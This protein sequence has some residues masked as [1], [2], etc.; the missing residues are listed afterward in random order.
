MSHFNANIMKNILVTIDFSENEKLLI[1]K[2]LEMAKA[3]NAKIWLLH[4]V[5]PEPE[6]VGFGVGP[7]YLRDSRAA[8]LRQEHRLIQ[9]YTNMVKVEN[10]ECEGLMINGATIEMIM[11]EAQKRKIDLIIAGHHDHGILYKAFFGS[12]ASGLIKKAN[13]PLLLVPLEK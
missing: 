6:F 8:E 5:S 10:Q 7:Q 9:D 11:K 1:D 2:A 12:V 3:F 4:V 13:I